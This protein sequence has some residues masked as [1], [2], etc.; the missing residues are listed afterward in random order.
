MLW[1]HIQPFVAVFLFLVAATKYLM[2]PTEAR[3]LSWFL[4][5]HGEEGM[6]WGGSKVV[7]TG[8]SCL[9]ASQ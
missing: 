3:V 5:H 2:E 8:G 9:L 4:V 6:V 1:R 7:G